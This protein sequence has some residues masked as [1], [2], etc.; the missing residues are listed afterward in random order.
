MLP[1][2]CQQVLSLLCQ[3]FSHMMIVV[4]DLELYEQ[5]V[6]RACV[7]CG[8]SAASRHAHALFCGSAV[9][10]ASPSPGAA[11]VFPRE[12]DWTCRRVGGD[13]DVRV[14]AGA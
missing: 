3:A 5:Q 12:A 9:P 4:D 11:S 2:C 7:T 13:V 1:V 14:C 6:R 8:C 10:A